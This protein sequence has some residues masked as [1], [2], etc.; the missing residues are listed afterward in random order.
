MTTATK[1][2]DTIQAAL[3]PRA[4]VTG[5]LK[6]RPSFTTIGE[7]FGHTTS[8]HGQQAINGMITSLK[9]QANKVK[10]KQQQAQ[11]KTTLQQQYNGLTKLMTLPMLYCEMHRFEWLYYESRL[12][13]YRLW[14]AS[15]WAT[16]DQ[17]GDRIRHYH[18]QWRQ[19]HINLAGFQAFVESVS[20]RYFDGESLLLGEQDTLLETLSIA[21]NDHE[22]ILHRFLEAGQL[23][24]PADDEALE[25]AIASQR[26]YW[27]NHAQMDVKAHVL[28][29]Q[30]K[31]ADATALYDDW[32]G[33][34][35]KVD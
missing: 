14:L 5:Y 3:T 7:L 24:I 18:Q 27:M 22:A 19:L 29:C 4:L 20:I 30:G 8:T 15:Q 28:E 11:V 17:H 32:L 34:V 10:D 26:D 12:T 9:E 1:R 35:L 2:L 6:N 16:L 13:T 25:Q 31:D 21:L 33:K 23:A